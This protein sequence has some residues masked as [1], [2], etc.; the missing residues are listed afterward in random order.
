LAINGIPLAT[1][2]SDELDIEFAVYRPPHKKADPGALSSN[3]ADVD[4]K[5]VVVVDDV[6][7]TGE[8]MEKTIADLKAMGAKPML[9][10]AIVNKTDFKDIDGVPIR[11]VVSARTLAA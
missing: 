6:I 5:D 9:I 8:T 2:I 1:H 4:G 7:G 10:L 11:S 3:Y